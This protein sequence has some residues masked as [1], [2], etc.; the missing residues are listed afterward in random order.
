MEQRVRLAQQAVKELN[1]QS[2]TVSNDA[3]LMPPPEAYTP[4]EVLE[5]EWNADSVDAAAQAQLLLERYDPTI[6]PDT[7][8]SLK[9]VY[10]NYS[11]LIE[12]AHNQVNTDSKLRAQRQREEAVDTDSRHA[13]VCRYTPYQNPNLLSATTYY[14]FSTEDHPTELLWPSIY[15]TLNRCTKLTKKWQISNQLLGRGRCRIGDDLAKHDCSQ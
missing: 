13:L 3:G 14:P 12:V 8:V 4:L 10:Q 5:L 11:K 1:I 7:H 9:Q 15:S 6:V 2:M